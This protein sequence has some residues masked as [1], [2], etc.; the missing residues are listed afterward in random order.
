MLYRKE[1]EEMCEVVRMMFDR[2]MTNAAGGNVSRRINEEHFILTPTLMAQ[3]KFCRLN[4]EDILVIDKDYNIIEGNGKLT[5]EVNMHMGVYKNHP[6]AKVVIHSH[7]NQTMLYAAMG[8]DMPLLCENVMK[9]GRIPCLEFAPACSQMLADR[10]VSYIKEK[11]NY[12][13][14]LAMILNKHGI[15][16]VG[17]ELKAGYDLLERIECNAYVSTMSK[18]Y[19]YRGNNEDHNYNLEE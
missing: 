16:I 15:L 12:T 19:G 10:V 7:P 18:I 2:N 3:Q 5:R 8:I 14:P 13:D 11:D 1:R 4:P 6:N 9:L 17:F